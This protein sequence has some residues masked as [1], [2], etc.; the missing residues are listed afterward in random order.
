MARLAHARE[1]H[2]ERKNYVDPKIFKPQKFL[3]RNLGEDAEKGIAK[4]L[5]ECGRP[6]S[7]P[8]LLLEELPLA[9]LPHNKLL[10]FW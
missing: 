3:F 2:E 7:D 8:T 1:L 5:A 6:L 9:S 10:Y 4:K